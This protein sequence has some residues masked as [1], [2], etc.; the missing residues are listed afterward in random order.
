MSAISDPNGIPGGEFGGGWLGIYGPA[1]VPKPTVDRLNKAF[2]AAF[3]S[4][5]VQTKM[6]NAGLVL[7]PVTTQD[8]LAKYTQDQRD[9]YIKTVKELGIER[10]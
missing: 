7:T 9:M 8:A 2:M 10:E 5:D 6:Y 3:N 4:Q 1:G